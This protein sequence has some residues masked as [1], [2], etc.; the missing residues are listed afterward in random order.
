MEGRNVRWYASRRVI[1][2]INRII[3]SQEIDS[4][5]GELLRDFCTLVKY[6]MSAYFYYQMNKNWFVYYVIT[7]LS[8][9]E[10]LSFNVRQS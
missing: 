5:R 8:V 2:A 7:K 10:K 9:K 6:L 3:D 1:L 4:K